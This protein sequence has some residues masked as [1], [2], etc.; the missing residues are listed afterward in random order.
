MTQATVPTTPL[1]PND[2]ARETLRQ[3]ASRALPP[4][5]DNYRA[6]YDKL[7][8][9]SSELEPFPVR[10]L[11]QVL[12]ALPR[13]SLEQISFARIVEQA[14]GDGTW[15]SLKEAMAHGV[16]SLTSS[17][18]DRDDVTE[19]MSLLLREGVTPFVAEDSGLL[20]SVTSLVDSLS[21]PASKEFPWR[22]GEYCGD[23]SRYSNNQRAVREALTR[24]LWLLVTNISVIVID[25]CWIRGQV[26][27]VKESAA[28]P[29]SLEKLG[30]VEMRLHGV[31]RTQSNLKQQL[32][33]AR[34]RIQG[35]L[36]GFVDHLNAFGVGAGAYH[37]TIIS[38][39]SQ[40]SSANSIV[41][42]SQVIE[43]VLEE[44]QRIQT[45]VADS[46]RAIRDM[47]AEV[48]DANQEI[49]RLRGELAHTS[50]LVRHDRLTG[51]LNRVGLDETFVRE[52]ART[53]RDGEPLCLAV[54]DIDDFKRINDEHGH[55]TGDAA[56]MHLVGVVTRSLR[57]QDSLARYGGEE[58]IILLT[59]VHVNDA[60]AAM[61]R[62]QRCLT[63]EFFLHENRR[64]LIT[65]SAG[66]TELQ[67]QDTLQSAF[68]RADEAMYQAKRDGKNRVCEG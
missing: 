54:L 50:E 9:R 65:F 40:I 43:H 28:P 15:S 53:Q 7:A 19:S 35:M 26:E 49:I 41:E 38:C 67:T 52:R 60:A 25:D 68:V 5:P 13:N 3:M 31:I 4:T 34:D 66:V 24:V 22:V 14:I 30:D 48:S 39:A 37:A 6:V 33:E 23:L 58:F 20:A 36:T 16:I 56:L 55:E 17:E 10:G 51:A 2:L 47:Q 46:E 63:S 32:Q 12:S 27:L 61:M 57:P 11:S 21:G 18:A 1:S 45:H 64:L 42:L 8:G 59:G 62:L 44:T 29:L